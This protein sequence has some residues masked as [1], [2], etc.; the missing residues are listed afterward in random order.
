MCRGVL[1]GGPAQMHGNSCEQ[2]RKLLVEMLPSHLTG[3][4]FW[5]TEV[6]LEAC[7]EAFI[8]SLVPGTRVTAKA[9]N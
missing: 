7:R 2:I 8:P 6:A 1:F 4:M 9:L 5:G 3:S